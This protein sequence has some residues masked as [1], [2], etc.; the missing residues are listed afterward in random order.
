LSIGLQF[1]RLKR[2]KIEIFKNENIFEVIQ[3]ALVPITLEPLK[4]ILEL[5]QQLNSASSNRKKI[6]AEQFNTRTVSS[7]LFRLEKLQVYFAENIKLYRV[8][9]E[10]ET[11]LMTIPDKN[12]PLSL[13]RVC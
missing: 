11:L 13:F 3:D 7:N 4:S 12:D 8:F 6:F 1:T 9:L 2:I 5:A 10:I